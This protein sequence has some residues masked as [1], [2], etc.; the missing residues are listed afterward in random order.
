MLILSCP[1]KLQLLEG[2]LRNNL[3]Q[4][5]LVHG[6]V[7]HINRGNP[8]GHEVLVDS[9]PKFKAVLTRPRREVATDDSD[10]YT[11][12][13]AAFYH[14]HD[15]YRTLLQDTDAVNWAQALRV[16]GHQDGLYEA[17]RDAAAA[18]QT[19]FSPSSYITYLHSD[20]NKMQARQLDP[21]LRLSTLNS[22]HVD[23]LNETWAYGGSKHSRGYLA[24]LV[25]SFPN[26]CIL[27]SNGRLVSWSILDP[28]GALAHGYTL[29]EYRGQGYIT[30]INKD[31]A[32]RV[33]AL[34]YPVYGNVALDNERMQNLN[35]LW[36]YQ[37]LAALCHII[38]HTPKSA[39]S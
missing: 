18:K 28:F 38:I 30:I 20:P 21:S 19:Q 5:L 31:L 9:W 32:M 3:P 17:S 33:H 13:Y 6:A 11:N 22:S 25:R 12:M 16:H 15:V 8:A 35:E 36:G 23:L 37:R 10:F 39:F 24:A 2:I 14:D 26:S 34:G 4:T 27:D 1:S 29:P 7:M